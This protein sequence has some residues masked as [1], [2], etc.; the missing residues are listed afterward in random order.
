M[1]VIFA[2]LLAVKAA[3]S[4]SPL[5]RRASISLKV[6]DSSNANATN[7]LHIQ[8]S[9]DINDAIPLLLMP[10]AHA[11]EAP[12]ESTLSSSEP[13][14]LYTTVTEIVT[15][16]ILSQLPASTLTL[17]VTLPPEIE[18]STVATTD[19][20]T[21]TST[22]FVEPSSPIPADPSQGSWPGPPSRGHLP[23]L[24]GRASWTCPWALKD[25]T[26]FNVTQRFGGA[27]L[28]FITGIP[29]MIRSTDSTP[30]GLQPSLGSQ[31]PPI[32]T[33][34][35]NEVSLQL[36]YP[37][38]SVNPGR[39]PQG[40]MEFYASPLEVHTARTVTLRYSVYFPK[41]FTWV[42]GGKLPGL[43]GGHS[44]CSG[45]NAALDCFST[46]LMWRQ[47][48]IGE[49][50]LVWEFSPLMFPTRTNNSR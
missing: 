41:D 27:N 24:P 22:V 43:Y 25:L 6:N 44:G 9:E 16:T 49:L 35:P 2:A 31:G 46:R 42:L 13:P 12:P 14:L 48:G 50:Y 28:R 26:P 45:G 20:V 17:S 15:T 3:P 36:L 30:P 33:W 19:T 29:P 23:N 37:K 34:H 32:T 11:S 7:A 38:G 39:K 1:T 21:A 5:Q 8:G 47:G 40:G 10:P 4:S 18:I